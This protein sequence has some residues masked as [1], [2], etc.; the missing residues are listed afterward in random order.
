MR[1]Y[2]P[3]TLPLLNQYRETGL[4]PAE[5]DRVVAEDDSEDSEYLALMTAAD[6]SAEL[7]VR[8]RVV[9]VVDRPVEDGP[10]PWSE[11]AAVHADAVPFTDP[12]DEPGWYGVQEVANLIASL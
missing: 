5:A 4:I 8:R 10:V 7:G 6:L 9:I 12:D 1:L 11:I 3:A 2:F